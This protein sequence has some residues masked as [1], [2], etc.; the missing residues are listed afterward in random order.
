MEKG[1]KAKAIIELMYEYGL[2]YNSELTR[3]R[4]NSLMKHIR[5]GTHWKH[6]SKYYDIPTE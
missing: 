6:I 3:K 4:I 2:S 5:K 1:Y